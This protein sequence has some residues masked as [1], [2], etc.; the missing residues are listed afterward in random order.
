MEIEDLLHKAIQVKRQLKSKT[1]SSSLHLLALYG[2]QIRKIGTNTSYRLHDIKCFRCQGV[3]HI[4]SQCP[5]KRAVVKLDNGEIESESSSDDEMPPLEDYSD[6]E[7][8][9]PINGDIL[10]TRHALSI[11]PKE[12]GD[13]EQHEHN[14]RTRCHINDKYYPSGEM[15][16]QTTKHHKP[17]K[18]QWLSNIGEVKVDKEVLVPFAIENYKDEVLYDVL[19]RKVN[20]NRYTNCLSSIYN[21]LKIPL[22]P[23]SPKQVC[24]DQIKISK[25]REY[26]LREEQLSIREKESKKNMSE[27]MQKKEKH[28]IE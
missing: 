16:L 18:L 28:E 1:L 20:H 17:Y 8:A 14:F 15:N 25:V 6:V 22:T 21:K 13:M 23:L 12:D 3:G 10:V 7:V 26:K 9:E 2:D 27:N 4:V 11:Q 19:N 5:Y 24:E